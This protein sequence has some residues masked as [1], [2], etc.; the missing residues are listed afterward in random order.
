MFFEVHFLLIAVCLVISISAVGCPNIYLQNDTLLVV[1]DIK[2][3][4]LT[5]MFCVIVYTGQW[6]AVLTI[7]LVLHTICWLKDC[8][9]NA[10]H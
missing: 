5:I 6:N 2:F 7:M 10:V 1:W 4:V 9:G 3:C 8:Y